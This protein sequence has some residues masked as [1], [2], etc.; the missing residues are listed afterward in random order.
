MK[1]LKD[2]VEFTKKYPPAEIFYQQS[3]EK[4]EKRC[5]EAC[6]RLF[7]LNA[8]S[9]NHPAAKMRAMWACWREFEV[10]I[11]LGHRDMNR[12]VVVTSGLAFTQ[13]A[14]NAIKE[15]EDA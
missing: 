15:M 6:S 13:A 10:L 1:E 5:Q 2:W 4:Q 3:K 12:I 14:A 11:K 9:V 8:D 7:S